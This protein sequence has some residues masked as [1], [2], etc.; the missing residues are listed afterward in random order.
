VTV[1]KHTGLIILWWNQRNTITGTYEQCEAAINNA[2]T[3]CLVAG[4]WSIAS[5]MVSNWISLYSNSKARNSLRNL[6]TQDRAQAA[7]GGYAPPGQGGWQTP[8]APVR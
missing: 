6:V 8:N 7:Y 4:W 3:H 5:I 2:Q 1:T